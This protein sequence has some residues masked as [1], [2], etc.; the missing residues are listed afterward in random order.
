MSE[1]IDVNE[2]DDDEELPGW[3]NKLLELSRNVK[4]PDDLEVPTAFLLAHSE[5]KAIM[6]CTWQ[7]GYIQAIRDATKVI[8]DEE[9]NICF[10]VLR[11]VGRGRT[12]S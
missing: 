4:A 8:N 2:V 10:D 3:I 12:E 1:P 11:E 5:A 9:T 6:G 7:L